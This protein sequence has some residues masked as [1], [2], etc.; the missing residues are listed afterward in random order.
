MHT[1]ITSLFTD[2]PARV[3]EL[4]ARQC[5]LEGDL[6]LLGAERLLDR[7]VAAPLHAL[8]RTHGQHH[9]NWP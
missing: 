9:L 4:V 5:E 8:E 6:D 2:L 3:W 1:S 7:A